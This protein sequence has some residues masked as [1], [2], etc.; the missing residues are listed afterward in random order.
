MM[1]KQHIFQRLEIIACRQR[2]LFQ[3]LEKSPPVFQTLEPTFK[4]DLN[5]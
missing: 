2:F 1:P 3:T 5:R 4:I